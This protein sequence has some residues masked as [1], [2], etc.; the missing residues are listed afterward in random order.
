MI[1]K[2]QKKPKRIHGKKALSRCY[3]LRYRY[4]DMLVDRWKS[5]G[6]TQKEVA[7]K[8]A[9]DFRKEWELEQAGLLPSVSVREA[10][11]RPMVD[12]LQDFLEDLKQRGKAGRKDEGLI[13]YRSRIQRLMKDCQWERVGQVTAESFIVW[14]NGQ[15][16]FSARTLNHYLEAVN[17]FMN[18][19]VRMGRIPANPL[20]CVSKVKQRGQETR[21]RRALTEEEVSRL[22]EATEPYR[23]MIYFTAART[24]FRRSELAAIRWQDVELDPDRP[25]IRARA[26]TTK[27]EKEGFI[28]LVPELREA[29]EA[30]K[31]EGVDPSALVF[32]AGIPRAEVLRQDLE[33]A[34]SSLQG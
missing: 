1:H 23:C 14:R 22:L 27:N 3:Y 34:G 21:Q 12:Q 18:F 8:R 16:A 31:P 5:L 20:V 32:P 28:P 6:V 13:K 17:A 33:G 24:G 19:L 15:T 26:S 25:F 11:K 30:F 9:D 29:L 2:I 7:E 10:G 4:G